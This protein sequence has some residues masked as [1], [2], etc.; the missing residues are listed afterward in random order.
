MTSR[1]L[2]LLP[3]GLLLAC[4]APADAIG[5]PPPPPPPAPATCPEGADFQQI[6]GKIGLQAK[7]NGHDALVILDTGAPSTVLDPTLADDVGAG[8]VAIDAAG[9][10]TTLAHVD[11]SPAVADLHVPGVKG[12]LGMD[13][14]G[15]RVLNVDYPRLRVWIDAA[16]DEAALAACTHVGAAHETAFQVTGGHLYARGAIEGMSGWF[17]IDSGASLGGTP[18]STFA[19]LQ[20]AHPRPALSGFWTPAAVGQFWA[21]LAPLAT[22]EV[23]GS[24]VEQILTR[25][26]DD[27][28]LPRK[29]FMDGAWL[30]L[31][32]ADFLQTHL[33]TID[34]PAGKLR[35]AQQKGGPFVGSQHY[36]TSGLGLVP[37]DGPVM[38]AEVLD[39][40]AAKEQGVEVGDELL[41]IGGSDVATLDPYSR[42]FRLL[43]P[44]A[45]STVKVRV[46]HGTEER[47]LDLDTRDLLVAPKVP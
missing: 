8:T 24:R 13:F 45:T 4:S 3:L 5:T 12:I 36:F 37:G 23:A 30:G 35:L 38:I 41:A 44:D 10:T 25:T 28:I 18:K 11:Y 19:A 43:G 20:A 15:A 9:T 32:P 46:R 29:K 7:L 40:S 2:L 14:V 17:L 21:Q 27:D 1:T 39:G 34:F 6:F 47:T 42:P 22:I 16:R 31:L 33:V 26:M